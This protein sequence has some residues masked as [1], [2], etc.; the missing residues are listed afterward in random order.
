MDCLAIPSVGKLLVEHA[1]CA[2]WLSYQTI[3]GK[4]RTVCLL[5]ECRNFK[6]HEYYMCKGTC[7]APGRVL[8]CGKDQLQIRLIRLHSN[9]FTVT[10]PSPSPPPQHVVLA[11]RGHLLL[12]RVTSVHTA[13]EEEREEMIRYHCYR[14]R[15]TPD[16]QVRSQ[17]F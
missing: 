6:L 2:E 7:P 9:F 12:L 8:Y 10:S 5:S 17:R 11:H 16:T 1:G 3:P 13:T 15:L 4:V 14:G